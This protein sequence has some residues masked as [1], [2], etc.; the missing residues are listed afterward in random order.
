MTDTIHTMQFRLNPNR[1]A[2]DW[3]KAHEQVARW[4]TGLPGFRF[5]T[6]AEGADGTWTLSVCWRSRADADAAEA[7]FRAEMFAVVSPFV[8]MPS[9]SGA[10]GTLHAM[11][12]A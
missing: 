10:Y 2:A 4:S 5:R 1:T 3:L 7:R 9:F 12:H 11:L 8:D 6:L